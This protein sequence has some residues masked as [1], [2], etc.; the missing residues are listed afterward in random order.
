MSSTNTPHSQTSQGIELEAFLS[1]SSAEREATA[2]KL[3]NAQ[4]HQLQQA[5]EGE[6]DKVLS[7]SEVDKERLRLV[8]ESR[9]LL[10]GILDLRFADEWRRGGGQEASLAEQIRQLAEESGIKVVID[11]SK[12]Q[13]AVETGR[14][15]EIFKS[16]LQRLRIRFIPQDQFTLERTIE[17]TALTTKS[18]VVRSALDLFVLL[19][20][21]KKDGCRIVLRNEPE[22]RQ[23]EPYLGPVMEQEDSN[24]KL[25][26]ENT[27][28]V[29]IPPSSQI[30]L[31][32]LI[33]AGTASS[34]SAAVRE[35]LAIYTHF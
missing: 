16:Q 18:E 15:G 14:L 24:A 17:Q 33:K 27:L 20:S 3:S 10:Q 4:L 30:Q 34:R 13:K 2:K 11:P 26:K 5:V 21:L 28:E 32:A 8:G 22:Q 19:W 6:L 35:A 1:Q 7:P 9:G 31:D 29:R 12:L 23:Y 25:T